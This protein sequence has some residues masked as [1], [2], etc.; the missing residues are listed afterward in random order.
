MTAELHRVGF[1][2]GARRLAS[3]QRQLAPLAFSLEDV[4]VAR[5][6]DMPDLAGAD[7]LRVLSAPIAMIP[8]LQ[9]RFPGFMIGVRQDYARSYIDMTG[10]FDSY[11]ARFSGKTRSTLRRK[12]RKFE[13]A[14]EG[15]LAL[16]A[17]RT[18]AEIETFLDLAVPLSRRTYQARLLDAGLPEG[19]SAR[20]EACELAAGDRLR[21]YLLFL[22][23]EP[24]AYLYLPVD[25]ATLVYAYL[26]YDPQH[27]SLSPG[28]VL[29]MAALEALFA[30]EQ[31]RFFDFTEG[32]GA[33]KALFGTHSADCASFLLL[34]PTLANRALIA[35]QAGF[36]AAVAGGKALARRSGAESA[37]RRMLGR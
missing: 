2:L 15:E 22:H 19:P 14:G 34:R 32:E 16:T 35:A 3:V 24:V 5:L 8:Q 25:G 7:G 29:Q 6:P 30:E 17:Y 20:A 37:L 23:G 13:Q 1:T 28:T 11:L 4:L 31:F 21:A 26:G 9:A 10:S 33:H 18:P 27:A 12:R 36:D